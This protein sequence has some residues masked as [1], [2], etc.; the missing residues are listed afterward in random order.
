MAQ[1]STISNQSDVQQLLYVYEL[2]ENQ[3]KAI[4]Q[5]I[6]MLDSQM[7]GVELSKK[8]MEEFQLIGPNHETLIPVGTNAYTSATLT[9]PDKV[10]VRI[11]SD[12][13][14]EKD[15]QSGIKSMEKLLT[16]YKSIY[17]KLTGQLEEVNGRLQQLRP[18]IEKIYSSRR[19]NT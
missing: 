6:A 2:L 5:Q 7:Q 14:I 10:L 15:L 13:L 9:N 12:V 11:N 8:T 19:N 4:R 3:D 1:N 16:S 17:E 18:E